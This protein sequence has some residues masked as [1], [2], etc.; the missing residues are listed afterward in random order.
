M[1]STVWRSFI[2]RGR[3]SPVLVRG[4]LGT[5]MRRKHC[6]PDTA[7]LRCLTKYLE[8]IGLW[9]HGLGV[10]RRGMPRTFDT[11]AHA[12]SRVQ[13]PGLG[14]S[15][16]SS[17]GRRVAAARPFYLKLVLQASWA[18]TG[19]KSREDGE[20]KVKHEGAHTHRHMITHTLLLL[21]NAQAT[22]MHYIF[23]IDNANKP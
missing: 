13:A 4:A 15:W 9:A 11:F 7:S 1:L 3:L 2:V 19:S 12:Q 10:R 5:F 16:G 18:W 14:V 20:V 21:L 22:F 6:T 23:G 8:P 17:R